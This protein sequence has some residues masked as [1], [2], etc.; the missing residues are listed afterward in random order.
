MGNQAIQV[1]TIIIWTVMALIIIIIE[2]IIPTR[3]I[4]WT[5]MKSNNDIT[6]HCYYFYKSKKNLVYEHLILLRRIATKRNFL[7]PPSIA[8]IAVSLPDISAS[9]FT[10][11]VDIDV[12]VDVAIAE[13]RS[14]CCHALTISHITPIAANPMPK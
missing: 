8:I 7:T 11:D 10:I 12:D 4:T 5:T 2:I 1:I 9:V 13:R 3:R 14:G 6:F